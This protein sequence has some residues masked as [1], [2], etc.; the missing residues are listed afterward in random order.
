MVL[1]GIHTT[2]VIRILNKR[3]VFRGKSPGD[4]SFLIFPNNRLFSNHAGKTIVPNKG[5]L[6]HQQQSFA[7][8]YFR[9]KGFFKIF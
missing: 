9:K 2:L 7:F 4:A 1:A 6:V 3:G 8:K 5:N